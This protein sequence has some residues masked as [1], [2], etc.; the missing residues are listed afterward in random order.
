MRASLK[1]TFDKATWTQSEVPV[2]RIRYDTAKCNRVGDACAPWVSE[3]DAIPCG[4]Y[5]I[6]SVIR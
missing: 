3:A 1:V 5:P 2:M 6:P 4:D